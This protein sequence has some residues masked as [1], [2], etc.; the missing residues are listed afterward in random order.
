MI[1]EEVRPRMMGKGA[2]WETVTRKAILSMKEKHN[3]NPLERNGGEG[4]G[5]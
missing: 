5:Q 2:I 1:S 4:E 3:G